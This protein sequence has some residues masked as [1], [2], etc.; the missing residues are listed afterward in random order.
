MK[1]STFFNQATPETHSNFC[2][3]TILVKWLGLK[4]ITCPSKQTLSQVN[5]HVPHTLIQ[6]Q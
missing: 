3:L 6:V 1:I 4:T 2:F 5:I